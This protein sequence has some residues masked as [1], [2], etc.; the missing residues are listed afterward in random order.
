MVHF[1]TTPCH[2]LIL[3]NQVPFLVELLI[4]RQQFGLFYY[5][6]IHMNSRKRFVN[7]NGAIVDENIS[8]ITK[9]KNVNVLMKTSSEAYCKLNARKTKGKY[10]NTHFKKWARSKAFA[11]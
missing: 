10:L 7:E 4:K 2:C 11:L 9:G 1:W 8:P 5:L 3:L 6:C